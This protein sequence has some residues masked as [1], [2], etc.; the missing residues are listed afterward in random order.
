M[1]GWNALRKW[2]AVCLS[3]ILLL[4]VST[5]A[6]ASK[7][8]GRDNARHQVLQS[9]VNNKNN[10]ARMLW[11]D[12]SANLFNLDTPE[13][14]QDIVMK[15]A[16]ANF[17]TIVLDI[18]NSTGYTAYTSN[19]APHISASNIPNY[20]GYPKEYDLLQTVIDEAK[21]YNLKVHAAIN[22]FSEGSTTYQEGP[23]YDHPEWQ[24]VLYQSSR[25]VKNERGS[26]FTLSGK[27]I[28]R[29]TNYLV[30]YTP[31]KYD[32]SP[33]NRWGAEM[34]VVDNMIVEISDRN[35]TGAEALKIPDNGYVLSGHGTA[36]TWLLENFN[37]GDKV[38]ASV[39]ESKF[40]PASEAP[41]ASTFVNPI[42]QEVE[43]YELG[44]IEELVRNYD[45][46][47]IVLDRARYNNIN[48]D[49]SD[50]SKVKFEEY[51]GQQVANWPEDTSLSAT[52]IIAKR[53]FKDHSTKNG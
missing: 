52:Q 42:H 24:S 21:K 25:V 38:D 27:N 13:K 20:Q 33:A 9:L 6:S 11:Y 28:T 14:V 23:A 22:V 1:K 45:I 46:D 3:I 48:A 36:R 37:V 16:N 17:D 4:G 49:F 34:Q 8:K 40:I 19:L 47:G 41:G 15:T 30:M 18:K 32:I 44:I 12:L 2:L 5:P 53:L 31:D 50:L 35:T 10:K 29:N 7:N 51:I 39:T 26:T 43:N